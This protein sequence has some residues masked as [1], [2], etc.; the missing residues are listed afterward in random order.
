VL[1]P[2]VIDLNAVVADMDTLLR[3][4]I[5]EDVDLVTTLAPG[6]GS[7]RADPAQIEQVIVNLAVNARDA[8]PR[9]GK[10]TL[11]TANVDLDEGYGAAHI[12]VRPGPH[13]MLAVSD[14]GLGMD[15]ATRARIFEPFFT[16]KEP[17]RGTG[18]GLSTVHGIVKQSGG[19]IWVYSEPGRGT[20]FKIYLPRT[21]ETAEPARPRPR[22]VEAP[23]GSETIL[24]VEDDEPVRALVREALE[25]HGYAVL[26]ASNGGEGLQVAE[27][28]QDPIHLVV[29]DVVMPDTTGPELAERLAARR[30]GTRVLFLSGYTGDA[31]IRHGMLA[32]GVAF[33]QKPFTPGALARRV[34]EVLDAPS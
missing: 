15:E 34:R 28:F 16:T 18:L 20:T 7:A 5:G 29:T 24:L 23:R 32:P 19:E 26:T 12:E 4:L 22:P 17:G 6:L 21:A 14:S 31:I 9:G 8:M 30:P 27:R 10:L 25:E 13:V 33:L 1:N 3:R 11:E 2:R